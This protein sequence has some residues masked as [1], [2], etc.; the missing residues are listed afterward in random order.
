MA[1]PLAKLNTTNYKTI[2]FSGNQFQM[3]EDSIDVKTEEEVPF[4]ENQRKGKQEAKNDLTKAR[5]H[6]KKKPIA[7]HFSI[8]FLSFSKEL[9]TFSVH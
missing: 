6:S 9:L 8:L 7:G 4:I 2:I 3:N 5:K 1:I